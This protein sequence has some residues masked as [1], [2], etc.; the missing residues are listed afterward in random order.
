M[1]TV[2]EQGMRDRPKLAQRE[3]GGQNTKV[4]SKIEHVLKDNKI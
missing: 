3:G 1:G 2:R 4:D